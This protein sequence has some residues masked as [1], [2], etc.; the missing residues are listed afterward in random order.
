MTTY[1]SVTCWPRIS[2][3]LALAC[4][5]INA[6][7]LISCG[8]D[9]R[10]E[11]VPNAH[12]AKMPLDIVVSTTILGDLVKN[13]VG[14]QATVEILL[15]PGVDPHDYHASAKQVAALVQADLVVVNGLF[16]E[17]GLVDVIESAIAEGVKVIQIAERVDPL[18]Y[19]SA[20]SDSESEHAHSDSE[21]EHAHS[22]SEHD[23]SGAYGRKDPHVWLDPIR[24]ADAAYIVAEE[25]VNIAGD[26][27][28]LS[29][30]NDYAMSLR[31]LDDEI[32]R[33]L[34]AI[35]ERNRKLVTNHHSL[36]YFANR[37]GFEVIGTVIPSSSTLADSSSAQL[38]TVVDAIK[39][40][41]V[42][43]IFAE[44]TNS[45]LL[46]ETVAREV[47][48]FVKVVELYTG[49][50]GETGSGADSLIGMLRANAARIAEALES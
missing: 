32:R 22:D 28:W 36:G 33:T 18:P 7:S 19:D 30:A 4:L 5:I 10:D 46:A 44:T 20:H 9:E 14:E 29:R 25:L 8:A 38:A 6:I 15:P 26:R 2:H 13:I 34:A 50:I 41:G 1:P 43:A 27:D 35:P 39:A 47:G 17:E 3:L 45:G 42:R 11:A 16:L 49:S 48:T 31:S 37:Y 21:S 12:A 40:A 24:M 23:H